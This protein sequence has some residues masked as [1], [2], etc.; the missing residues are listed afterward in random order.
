MFLKAVVLTLALVAITGTR[1]EVSADQV[2]TVMWD[3]F[4]QLSNNAKEA[5]EQLQKSDITQ[6]LKN[7][8]T[9]WVDKNSGAQ[10]KKSKTTLQENVDNLQA[11]MM[12]VANEFKEKFDRNV[13]E[14]KGR[15]TPHAS[16]LKATI[17]KNLEDLRSS[18][19][20]LAEGVQE[21]LNHQLEGLAFQMK[22]N[23]EELQTQV[24]AKVD[25]LQ[26]KLTPLVEDVHSKLKG[27]TEGLQKSLEDLNSQLD[28]QV[29]EFRRTVEPLGEMFNRALVQQMEQFRQQLGSSSGDV[30]GHLSFLEKSLRDKVSSFMGTLVKKESPD[31]PLALPVP[32]EQVQE[33]MQPNPLES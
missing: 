26:K 33:Q 13:E 3:Y 19:A 24:S 29:E 12:P 30:Q 21:K 7:G 32:E 27:N 16:E 18:L 20:P 2:A 22:K 15:L 25:Q 4:T 11:S 9:W 31:Q 8:V 23:A 10:Q 28:Q 5:V 1:A 6:Q 14:L 17:D